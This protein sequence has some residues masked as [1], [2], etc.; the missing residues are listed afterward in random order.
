L[1]QA[2]DELVAVRCGLPVDHGNRATLGMAATALLTQR[3]AV[4]VS[5]SSLAVAVTAPALR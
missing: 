4:L 3:I 1:S 2:A 5:V